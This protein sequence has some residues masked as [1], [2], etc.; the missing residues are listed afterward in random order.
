MQRWKTRKILIWGKT[1]PELSARYRE[2]VCTGGCFE[3]GSPI[4]LYP[5]PFRYLANEKQFRL[6]SWIEA[7]VRKSRSDSRPESYKVKWQAIDIVGPR[8]GTENGWAARREII[9]KDP[10]W[11][12]DCLEQLKDEQERS[13]QSLGV[14]KP[15]EI[16]RIKLEE[17]SDEERREHEKK[18]RDLKAQIDLFGH[19]MKELDFL[20]FR[21]KLWWKCEANAAD[22]RCPGHSATIFDWGL[23]VLGMRDG[24]DKAL[25]RIDELCDL[26]QYD[27]HLFMGNINRR[28]HIF[29]NVGLWYPKKMHMQQ[30][31]LFIS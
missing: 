13:G 28:R 5:I 12:F 24:K 11:H 17:R 8:L 10:S 20:P 19:E 3:D 1:A 7:P 15:R 4:R 9:F 30:P 23:Y 31:D 18:L 14:V 22:V 27:L 25:A 26:D 2:T 16:T 21:V 29:T 6:Y